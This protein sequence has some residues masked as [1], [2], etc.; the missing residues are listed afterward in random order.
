MREQL[1]IVAALLTV[2][3]VV[4][5]LRDTVRGDTRPQRVSWFVYASLSTVAAVALWLDGA[6]AA[7]WLASGAAVG[8]SAVFVAS[9]RYGV[10][11]SSTLD[12]VALAI[13][14]VGGAASF[15]I[16][17]PL[18]AVAA[19]IVAE[20][21]ATIPTVLKAADDPGS[22]TAVTWMMDG[23]AGLLAIAAVPE[24]SLAEVAYPFHHMCINLSVLAG[25]T[26]GRRRLAR[27]TRRHRIDAVLDEVLGEV[28]GVTM[29][30]DVG[31]SAVGLRR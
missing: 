24:L 12:R 28:L 7:T 4:P 3:C 18:L 2:A 25:I 22:E 20:Q 14:A 19:V 6:G 5:Y 31:E 21:A 26:V 9:L 29:R 8:F 27:R 11:G 16:A 1:A 30:F 17:E 15:A 10:G 23:T 13:A